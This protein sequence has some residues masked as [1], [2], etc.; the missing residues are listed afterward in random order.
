MSSEIKSITITGGTNTLVGGVPKRRRGVTRKRKNLQVGGIS[1]EGENYEQTPIVTSTTNTIGGQMTN[2]PPPPVITGGEPK[3]KVKLA[4]K[5]Q[6]HRIVLVKKHSADKQPIK[7]YR[8]H[9]IKR[10]SITT[11]KI[12]NKLKKANTTRKAAQNMHIDDIKKHLVQKKIIKGGSNAPP[13]L[14]RK[15]YEDSMIVANS[16]L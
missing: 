1:K 11:D 6:T 12:H 10:I 5:R 16:S 15:M 8:K 14:L 2:V 13:E 3:I 4:P 7:H 9:T